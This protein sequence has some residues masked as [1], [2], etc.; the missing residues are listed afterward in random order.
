MGRYCLPINADSV[1]H[2]AK[3]SILVRLWTP[4]EGRFNIKT[5]RTTCHVS[6]VMPCCGL[7]PTRYGTNHG[8]WWAQGRA[9]MMSGLSLPNNAP[10]WSVSGSVVLGW[11]E[12]PSQCSKLMTFSF[13]DFGCFS[14]R[15]LYLTKGFKGFLAFSCTEPD[16]RKCF[17]HFCTHVL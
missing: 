6:R 4:M 7:L 15:A 17:S 10:L 16:V 13:A 14:W 8:I 12:G 2:N 1:P 9:G 3:G 5:C 11:A